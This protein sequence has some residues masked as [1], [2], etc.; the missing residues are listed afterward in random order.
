VDTDG[1]VE[2]PAEGEEFPAGYVA[3]YWSWV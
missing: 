1:F 2:L 3:K